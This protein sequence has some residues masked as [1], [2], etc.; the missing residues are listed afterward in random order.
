MAQGGRGRQG[1]LPALD[2]QRGKRRR[3]TLGDRD[4]A[5]DPR[6]RC[7]RVRRSAAR[8]R[9]RDRPRRKR[10]G[11]E[12]L[13]TDVLRARQTVVLSPGQPAPGR[14]GQ[15]GVPVQLPDELSGGMIASRALGRAVA[16][17]T[18]GR[19]Y[20]WPRIAAVRP[21]RAGRDSPGGIQERSRGPGS[22]PGSRIA[23]STPPQPPK[24]RSRTAF[25]SQP[26]AG[27]PLVIRLTQV[28]VLPGPLETPGNPHVGLG[29]AA[30]C[31]VR[32]PPSGIPSGRA[33]VAPD[34]GPGACG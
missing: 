19:A 18:V 13:R 6:S 29:F 32:A 27:P 20:G 14:R 3:R 10:R 11:R 23:R 26:A 7:Q 9:R 12:P 25:P 15:C 22:Q 28:R 2:R 21:V 16:R 17:Q 8:R 34:R 31:P 4:R 24:R 33:G 5:S 1:E 30:P